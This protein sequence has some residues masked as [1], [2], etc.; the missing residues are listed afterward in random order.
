LDF[1]VGNQTA[2]LP[3][4]FGGFEGEI[5]VLSPQTTGWTPIQLKNEGSIRQQYSL[6]ATQT[7]R[8][9]MAAL[10]PLKGTTQ[11][12]GQRQ[13]LYLFPQADQNYQLQFQYYILP[14]MLNGQSPFVYGGAAHVET[15]LESCLAI[16]EQR[17]DDAVSV[18]TMKFAER[19]MASIGMDRKNKP[20]NLGY[21][22]DRSD[23]ARWDRRIG[24]NFPRPATYMGQNFG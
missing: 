2:L 17:Y 18:H 5:T 13:Q 23:N 15:I 19:L 9:L 14:D 11:Y 21:N 8:P 6:T 24:L 22:G 4:D 1:A 10:Q 12:S 20:Q 3:E 16:A 7:G